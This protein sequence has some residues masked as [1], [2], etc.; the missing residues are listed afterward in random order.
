MPQQDSAPRRAELLCLQAI[1]SWGSERQQWDQTEGR[2]R[3]VAGLT[4]EKGQGHR[5]EPQMEAGLR[6]SQ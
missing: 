6:T 1:V 3:H 4:P 5:A 2:V